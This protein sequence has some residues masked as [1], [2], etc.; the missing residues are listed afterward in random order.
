MR[1]YQCECLNCHQRSQIYFQEPYPEIGDEFLHVCKY[2]QTEA[3]FTRVLTRKAEAELRREREEADLKQSIMDHSTQYGFGCRFLFESVIIT[4][5]IA[6]WS[7]AYHESLKTLYHESTIKI[8]FKTGDYAKMHKQFSKRKMT[9][10]EVID[11][12]AAHDHWR[13]EQMPRDAVYREDG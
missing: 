13:Q 10:M 2:C 12:I 7:F 1:C 11:Y 8:N 9:C 3:P 6:T 4:T 5:P